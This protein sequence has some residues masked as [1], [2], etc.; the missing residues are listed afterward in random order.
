MLESGRRRTRIVGLTVAVVVAVTVAV[1]IDGEV[2]VPEWAN[3]PGVDLPFFG[4]DPLLCD[5]VVVDASTVRVELSGAPDVIDDFV[6]VHVNGEPAPEFE[7]VDHVAIVLVPADGSEVHLSVATEP[8]VD[9]RFW[10]GTAN[11]DGV[12]E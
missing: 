8:G 3:V 6:H 1:M 12:S 2:D 4:D 7:M 11:R 9:E 10:C 5:L